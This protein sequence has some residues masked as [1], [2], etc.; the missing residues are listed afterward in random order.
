MRLSSKTG[1]KRARTLR[2]NMSLPE[3]VLWRVL[4]T[5]PDG[6]K[7]RRQHPAGRY[8]LDFYC[9]AARLAVE[10]DGMAHNMGDNPAQDDARD[11]WL[12]GHDVM[13]LRFAASDVLDDCDACIRQIV[14]R[15]Q[16]L[17]QPSAGPPPLQGGTW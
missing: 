10:V 12:A 6:F 16:P 7:F 3:A 1:T 2:R 13:V 17:H 8:V 15:C 14:D 5:R 4:R 9:E 11:A